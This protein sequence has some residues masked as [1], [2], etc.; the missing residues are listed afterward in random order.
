MVEIQGCSLNS[1]PTAYN[2]TGKLSQSPLSLQLGRGKS[3]ALLSI[4]AEDKSPCQRSAL[5]MQGFTQLPTKQG[6]ESHPAVLWVSNAHG[7]FSGRWSRFLSLSSPGLCSKAVYGQ[8]LILPG[9]PSFMQGII[10]HQTSAVWFSTTSL[11]VFRNDF[12]TK[13]KTGQSNQAFLLK[14]DP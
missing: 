12:D 11:H 2:Q 4:G 8:D 13:P 5:G 10:V 9:S 3:S 6:L 7:K 14:P 1:P